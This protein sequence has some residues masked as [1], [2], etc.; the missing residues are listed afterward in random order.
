MP[1]LI[2]T[3]EYFNKITVSDFTDEQRLAFREIRNNIKKFNKFILVSDSESFK[4]TLPYFRQ[5]IKELDALKT[6]QKLILAYYNLKNQYRNDSKYL[7]HFILSDLYET[8][9]ELESSNPIIRRMNLNNLNNLINLVYVIFSFVIPLI[10]LF[11][12][13]I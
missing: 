12:P 3:R 10:R 2:I 9:L 1:F 11:L 7:N 5:L 8:D 4:K 6:P 13:Q